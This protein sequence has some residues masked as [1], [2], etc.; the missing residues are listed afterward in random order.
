MTGTLWVSEEP[1]ER[2]VREQVLTSLHRVAHVHE[3]GHARTLRGLM[4]QEGRVMARAGCAGPTLDPDDLE[5]TRHVL[6]PL[7]VATD[8]R[9]H[10]ECLFGD[11]AGATLGFTPRGLSDRAGLAL[12]LNDARAAGVPRRAGPGSE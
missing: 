11:A 9:T 8:M 6:E 5:Y 2:L 3:H 12:A 10:I 7:L 1:S 4:A